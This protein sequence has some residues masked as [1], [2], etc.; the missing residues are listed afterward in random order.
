VPNGLVRLGFRFR[1]LGS[2]FRRVRRVRRGGSRRGGFMHSGTAG[3]RNF[4]LNTP[5]LADAGFGT[6]RTLF[7]DVWVTKNSPMPLSF[8]DRDC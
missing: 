4:F 2:C 6:C 7:D 8:G 1:R 3:H 5:S